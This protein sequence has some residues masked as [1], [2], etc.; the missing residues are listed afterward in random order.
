[1]GSGEQKKKRRIQENRKARE[2]GRFLGLDDGRLYSQVKSRSTINRFLGG[3]LEI[4]TQKYMMLYKISIFF[5]ESQIYVICQ[6]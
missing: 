5:D 2:K 3:K 1:M 6:N 4:V